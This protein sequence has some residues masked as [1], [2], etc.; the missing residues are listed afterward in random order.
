MILTSEDS[1]DKKSAKLVA[2]LAQRGALELTAADECCAHC[3]GITM[4]SSMSPVSAGKLK[5][6]GR[7]HPL[8]IIAYRGAAEARKGLE[9]DVVPQ[10]GG[11]PLLLI[12]GDEVDPLRD[13]R[14]SACGCED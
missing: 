3:A 11:V 5:R 9:V 14:E 1:G 13:Y 4:D 2:R 6:A 10:P 7:G 12:S 8:S